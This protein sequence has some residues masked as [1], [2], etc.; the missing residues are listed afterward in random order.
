VLAAGG[1]I[2][3]HGSPENS[4]V[5]QRLPGDQGGRYVFKAQAAPRRTPVETGLMVTAAFIFI[6]GSIGYLRRRTSPGEGSGETLSERIAL[7]GA[8]KGLA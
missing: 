7:S 6:Y 5:F 8:E 1:H 2:H 3:S 4:I